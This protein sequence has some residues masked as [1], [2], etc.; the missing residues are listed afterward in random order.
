METLATSFLR[1]Y[2]EEVLGSGGAENEPPSDDDQR[3]F[4]GLSG[5]GPTWPVQ[6]KHVAVFEALRCSMSSGA[7]SRCA[8][9][10]LVLVEASSRL[11]HF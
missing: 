5:M 1:Q 3:F 4:D 10:R 6:R 2:S 7:K 11:W 9:L 8:L